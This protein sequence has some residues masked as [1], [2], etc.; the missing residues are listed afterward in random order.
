MKKAAP[1]KQAIRGE[2]RAYNREIADSIFNE[3]QSTHYGD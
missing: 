2:I 3:V 1:G